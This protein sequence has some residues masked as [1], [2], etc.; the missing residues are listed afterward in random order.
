MKTKSF[1][2]NLK[3]M[4]SKEK[5]SYIWEYY[6]L[7]IISTFIL[8]FIVISFTYS[9][10]TKKQIYYNITYIGNYI[11]TNQLSY[12]N[13]SLNN[14]ILHGDDKKTIT[15]DCIFIDEQSVKSTPQYREKLMVK[16]AAEEI[17][18]A[19]VDKEF[20]ENNFSSN[21][22]INLESLDGFSSLLLSKQELLERIDSNGNNGIYGINVRN[23]NLLKDIKFDTPDTFLVAMSNSDKIDNSLSFLKFFLS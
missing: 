16:V 8:F 7:H 11:D 21:I 14:V 18:M 19:I 6:K 2:D 20:F 3:S 12:M 10:V 9:Q 13:D 17:D 5:G 23:L 1:K 4:S 22:F 15:L